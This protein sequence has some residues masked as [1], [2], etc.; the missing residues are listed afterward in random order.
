MVLTSSQKYKENCTKI[1]QLDGNVSLDS[2]IETKL[3][4]F[5]TNL[6]KKSKSKK[7]INKHLI[8]NASVAH[9]LPVVTVCN[10][11][12]LF[13]KISNFKNDF[14][15]RSVDF[16]LCCEVWQKS[17]SQHHKNEIEKC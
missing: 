6:N 13:P 3:P 10:I 1:E 2:S 4:I 16:S 9:H 11:R 7:V 15:E 17:E 12:S 8:K 5:D 14:L